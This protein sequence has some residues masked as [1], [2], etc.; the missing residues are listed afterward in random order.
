MS[1]VKTINFGD[2]STNVESR[3]TFQPD[4]NVNKGLCM[5]KILR[6]EIE[7]HEVPKLKE[8]GSL[9]AWEFAGHVLPTLIIEFKQINNDAKDT[10][11]RFLIHR[12]TI[13]GGKSN[14]EPLEAKTWED[15]I[16]AQFNRLQH[17]VN[18]LDKA[19]VGTK[20]KN[21]G[22]FELSS[23]DSVE[24]KITKTKKFFEH[25]VKQIK[26]DAEKPRYEGILFW[27]RVIAVPNSFRYYG[28]PAFVGQGFIEVIKQGT[29]PTIKIGVN[30]SIVL[31]SGKQKAPAQ[32]NMNLPENTGVPASVEDVLKNLG[33]GG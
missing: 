3:L 28:L 24:V 17:I 6:V 1:T 9:S 26:G 16:T 27:M 2:L 31:V 33:Y 23:A 25:F 11:E 14:G 5:G 10:A 19:G 15:L 30:D 12:E 18:V 22:K 21:L 20:S 4:A 7:E 8:D 32:N 29:A 13:V